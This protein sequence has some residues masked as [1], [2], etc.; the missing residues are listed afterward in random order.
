P[1][2]FDITRKPNAHLTFGTGR[3]KCLGASLAQ[4]EVRVFFE[5]FLDRV[6][7]FEVGEP[8]R[9]RSNFIRGIK[10]LPVEVT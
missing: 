4:L 6:S 7:S 2:T 5:E 9:L 10:H 1:Y 3:H 8:D